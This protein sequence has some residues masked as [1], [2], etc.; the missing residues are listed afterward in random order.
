MFVLAAAQGTIQ[1]SLNGTTPFGS[2]L[3]AVQMIQMSTKSTFPI[4]V[5]ASTDS[6]NFHTTRTFVRFWAAVRMCDRML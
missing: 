5:K 1:N 4:V 6:F 2:V 3:F